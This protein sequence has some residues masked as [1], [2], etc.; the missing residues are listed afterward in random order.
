MRRMENGI[1]VI[2][3]APEVLRNGSTHYPYRFDSH[4]YYLTGFTEPDAVLVLLAGRAP[5]SIL[6]CRPKD[7]EREIWEGFRYGPEAAKE[8][9]EF[10]E[11]YPIAQ[12]DEKLVE[13]MCNQPVLFHPLG[14]DPAWDRRLIKIRTEVQAKVRSGIRAPDEIR[15]VR[16]LLDEMRLIKSSAEIALMRKAAEISAGAHI[17][18]MLACRPGMT[19]YEIEAELLHEFRRNG[20]QSPSYPPIVAGGTNACVLHYVDNNAT[21]N[22][23]EL[24]LIDAACEVD[25]YAADITRTFPVNGNFIGAQKDIYEMVL[26]AQNAAIAACLPGKRWINPHEAAV[27]V[28]AQG[29]IDFKLLAGSLDSVL[30]SESYKRFYMHRT[31]HWLGLDVHDVGAYKT[32]NEWR[33]LVPGMTFTVEPGCYIRPSDD[34]PEA[35]WNI[36]VRIEDNVVITQTGCE[37]LTGT[38]LK[39]VEVIEE[40][41][42]P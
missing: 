37:I 1:A 21:L 32:N 3:T 27:K 10:D 13:L 2:P 12:L 33:E 35:F 9:F 5:R 24:L 16:A 7:Q 17:R 22:D 15:D 19:E 6:F 14:K 36:G 30:E 41:M 20:A 23:G 38:A 25:G 31:G 39:D 40:L 18:A 26:A 34:V 8:A 42:K 11:A 4:F 28:I 29:L